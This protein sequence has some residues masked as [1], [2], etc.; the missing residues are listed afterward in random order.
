MSPQDRHDLLVFFFFSCLEQSENMLQAT[1]LTFVPRVW[2]CLCVCLYVVVGAS[3][4]SGV[5]GVSGCSVGVLCSPFP[6][7]LT[8]QRNISTFV[9]LV[10]FA[11]APNSLAVLFHPLR[12]SVANQLEEIFVPEPG[13]ETRAWGWYQSPGADAR[14]ERVVCRAVAVEGGFLTPAV[15][16]VNSRLHLLA[17]QDEKRDAQ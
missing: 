14:A 10:F 8:A 9:L 13:M 4:S 6:S 16:T 15:G 1:S 11:R 2:V 3:V 7:L 5:Q 17:P 12:I